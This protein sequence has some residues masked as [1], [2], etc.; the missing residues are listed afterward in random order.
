VPLTTTLPVAGG[1]ERANALITW[2]FVDDLT[3]RFTRTGIEPRFWFCGSCK[4][5]NILLDSRRNGKGSKDGV[6]VSM[7]AR[8]LLPKS[9]PGKVSK[10][11]NYGC[12]ERVGSEKRCLGRA[13]VR[14]E[15]HFPEGVGVMHTHFPK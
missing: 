2:S 1:D 8:G 6:L 10:D 11:W 3:G 15:T 13:A 9:I 4:D 5:K 14:G 7:L 12:E